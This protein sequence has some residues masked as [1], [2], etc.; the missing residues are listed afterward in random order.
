MADAMQLVHQIMT[1]SL[2]MALP[3]FG[4]YWLD[5]KLK[6]G[7]WLLIAG[8]VLGMLAGM[9]QLVKLVAALGKPPGG[10]SRGGGGSGSF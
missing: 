10:D 7:P 5:E 1:I 4:G 8:G 3:P 2:T 6:T 9:L